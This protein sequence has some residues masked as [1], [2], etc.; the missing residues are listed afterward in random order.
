MSDPRVFT[1]SSRDK[2]HLN[3]IRV[4]DILRGRR[5]SLRR[6]TGVCEQAFEAFKKGIEMEFTEQ[7]EELRTHQRSVINQIAEEGL[8]G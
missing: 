2:E 8:R 4:N 6:P 7:R 1:V 5:E 3:K